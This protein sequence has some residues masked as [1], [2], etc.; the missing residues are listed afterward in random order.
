MYTSCDARAFAFR[1]WRIAPIQ[2]GNMN[3]DRESRICLDGFC[4]ISWRHQI[5]KSH[6]KPCWFRWLHYCRY[7]YLCLFPC[8]R[9]WFP[10]CRCVLA[11]NFQH[12]LWTNYIIIINIY[13]ALVAGGFTSWWPLCTALFAPFVLSPGS[14]LLS[15]MS[16]TSQFTI[17]SPTYGRKSVR[18]STNIDVA[19]V[20][21]Y[22]YMARQKFDVSKWSRESR[23]KSVCPWLSANQGW[24][25]LVQRFA[26]RWGCWAA[27][28]ASLGFQLGVHRKVRRPESPQ[29][30]A[31]LVLGCYSTWWFSWIWE[32]AI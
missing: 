26:R 13:P 6:N 12:F 24:V 27:M 18:I 11:R 3:M 25:Y 32:T 17:Q 29:D 16:H 22:E 19:Y 30:P 21:V 7:L 15:S 8:S 28:D 1:K 31:A 9:S 20:N 2:T 4:I 14:R 10:K 23:I 5:L